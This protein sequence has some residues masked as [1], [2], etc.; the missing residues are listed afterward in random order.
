MSRLGPGPGV[1]VIQDGVTIY[2]AVLPEGLIVVL[3]GGAAAVW[4]ASCDGERSSIV[5]RVAG[6]TGAR[7]ADIRME[8]ESFVDDLIQRGLLTTRQF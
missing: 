5:E 2:A 4:I 3:D 1:G 6:M 7:A 8:V